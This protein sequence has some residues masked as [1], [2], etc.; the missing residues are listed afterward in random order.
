MIICG[1]E[2][3]AHSAGLP[4]AQVCSGL[5]IELSERP[6]RKQHAFLKTHG[7]KSGILHQ[8]TRADR[9]FHFDFVSLL[10]ALATNVSRCTLEA[11]L[12]EA[13]ALPRLQLVDEHEHHPGL[14]I[15]VRLTSRH[16]SSSL[17]AAMLSW[18]PVEVLWAAMAQSTSL[19]ERPR[20]GLQNHLFRIRA[21]VL[22]ERSAARS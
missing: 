11:F 17:S 10:H 5:P 4:K 14:S 8:K 20:F 16:R 18:H 6:Q 2:V 21:S 1:E 19:R 9:L 22:H 15:C 3:G 7:T 12:S 13:M